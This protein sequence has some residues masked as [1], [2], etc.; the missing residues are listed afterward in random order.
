M[1]ARLETGVLGERSCCAVPV[2]YEDADVVEAL[3]QCRGLQTRAQ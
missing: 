2:A 3:R 1:I